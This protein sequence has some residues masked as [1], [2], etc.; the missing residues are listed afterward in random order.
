MIVAGVATLPDRVDL[1]AQT[2][3]SLRPQVDLIHVFLN[4]HAKVPAYLIDD[5]RVSWTLSPSNTG[6]TAKFHWG[7][8]NPR[9][10]PS[11]YV[12]TCDDDLIY[13]SD[14]AK[15]LV[16]HCEATGGDPV[17]VLGGILR[18]PIQSYYYSRRV[19]SC[20]AA[21]D[22]RRQVHVLGTGTLC[23]RTDRMTPTPLD[24]PV[25]NMADVWF[26]ILAKRRN[27]RL[28]AAPRPAN[29]LKILTPPEGTTIFSQVGRDPLRHAPQTQAIRQ[30][31]PWP[32][33]D[34]R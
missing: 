2:V 24:F 3:A 32:A 22:A 23:Y 16:L 11:T 1:L 4:G 26:A 20:T 10:D 5:P 28:W 9:P 27:V 33:L 25:A 31:A 15:T 12:L 34:L 17:G 30:A 29:W 8:N 19:F 21:L 18:E 6:D 14:Y 13:P 7:F